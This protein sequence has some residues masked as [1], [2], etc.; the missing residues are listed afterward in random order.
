MTAEE[1]RKKLVNNKAFQKGEMFGVEFCLYVMAWV[2]TEDLHEPSEKVQ[3]LLDRMEDFCVDFGKG[4]INIK[5]MV[6]VLRDEHHITI[7]FGGKIR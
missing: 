7:N 3:D 1:R 5:D 2:M 6:E 4:N